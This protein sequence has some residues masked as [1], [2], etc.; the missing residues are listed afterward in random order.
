MEIWEIT[1]LGAGGGLIAIG[2][3]HLN[4]Y[5]PWKLMGFDAV[6]FGLAIMGVVLFVSPFIRLVIKKYKQEVNNENKK[7]P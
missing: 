7:K 3:Q 2:L 4:P 6:L 1:A 5:E